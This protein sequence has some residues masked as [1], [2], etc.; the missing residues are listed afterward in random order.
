MKHCALLSCGRPALADPQ[1]QG[2]C[3]LHAPWDGKD[4]S[5]FQAAI[6]EIIKESARKKAKF[7][8]FRTVISPPSYDCQ[9]L[10]RAFKFQL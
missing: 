2:Y 7:V 9:N 1:A 4:L 3:I 10:E 5:A 8:T 6:D